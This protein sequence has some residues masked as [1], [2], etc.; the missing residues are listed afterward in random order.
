MGKRLTALFIILCVLIAAAGCGFGSKPD[1][2]LGG[3]INMSGKNNGPFI[4]NLHEVTELT[5]TP[6]TNRG[7]WGGTMSRL[8]VTSDG[9]YTAYMTGGGDGEALP[10][11]FTLYRLAPGADTW[12]ALGTGSSQTDAVVTLAGKDGKI[13]VATL[14][15]SDYTISAAVYVYNPKDAS[16][17]PYYDTAS[18]SSF[19]GEGYLVA[20][21]D[22]NGLI[23]IL[24]CGG[25][26]PGSFDYI[27]FDTK[28]MSFAQDSYGLSLDYRHCY[29]YMHINGSGAMELVA[30][31]D[32]MYDVAGY[33]PI[34]GNTFGYVFDGVRYFAINK[35]NSYYLNANI[36]IKLRQANPPDYR[37]TLTTYPNIINNYTGDTYWDTKGDTHILYTITDKS[38]DMKSETW[39]AV[40]SGGKQKYNKKL[41]DGAA[42]L[43]MI[44]DAKGN[45]YL[46]KM[47]YGTTTLELYKSDAG[48]GITFTKL[49]EYDLSACNALA[50]AGLYVAKPEGGT[51]IDNTVDVIYPSNAKGA[52]Y[53]EQWNYFRLY[54]K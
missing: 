35:P 20:T 45:Y 53:T 21:I 24:M 10:R 54:L 31:R 34:E 44:Q 16:F 32:V 8:V 40:I 12:E 14:D 17:K 15:R 52:Q 4:A 2:K 28:S 22:E 13:Y 27:T 18:L 23:Y 46:L 29:V 50:Y 39:Y 47:A 42:S 9:V 1:T 6:T 49:G 19:S 25:S 41:W 5:K 43:R 30:E 36:D 33:P 3:I 26:A 11:A 48:D 51:K 37:G 7:V 38:T